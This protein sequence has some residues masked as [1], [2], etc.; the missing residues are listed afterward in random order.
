MSIEGSSKSQKNTIKKK[1]ITLSH[2]IDES[3]HSDSEEEEP[4][5]KC[6]YKIGIGILRQAYELFVEAGLKGLTLMETAQLLGVRFYTCRAICKVLKQNNLLR[7][8][9][10]DKGRQRK[11]R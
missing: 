7:E 2:Q 10:E 5:V 11:A 4:P 9:L 3:S 8:F 6:Q 1:I